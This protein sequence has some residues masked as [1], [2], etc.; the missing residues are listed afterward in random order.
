MNLLKKKVHILHLK[1]LPLSEGKFQFDMW[2]TNPSEMWD[3]ET[4]REKIKKME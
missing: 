3:W 1:D 2:N 4:L